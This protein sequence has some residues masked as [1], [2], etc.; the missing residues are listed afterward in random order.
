M[1]KPIPNSST[2]FLNQSSVSILIS[3]SG[4]IG[5]GREKRRLLTDEKPSPEKK[6]GLFSKKAEE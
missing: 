6:G 3:G 1:L 2:I 5:D 4:C